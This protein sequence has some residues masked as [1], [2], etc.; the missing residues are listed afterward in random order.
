MSTTTP[1][2]EST[3][4][5]LALVA[6]PMIWAAHLLIAYAVAAVFC[7]KVG[8]LAEGTLRPVRLAIAVLTALALAGIAL[9]GRGGWRRHRHGSE[10]AAADPHDADTPED[11]HRFLGLATALLAGLSAVAVLYQALAAV[12][13]G[14]CR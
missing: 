12:F 9:V 1:P 8:G 11:R 10:R 5:L 7:A 4:S 14:S 13:V 6:G 3:R 2:P